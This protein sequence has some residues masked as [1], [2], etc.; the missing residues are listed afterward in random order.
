M[1][2]AVINTASEDEF[3][4]MIASL[5]SYARSVEQ[6]AFDMVDPLNEPDFDGIEGPQVG[7]A[8]YAGILRK[9]ALK[10]DAMGLTDIKFDGPNTSSVSAAVGTYIPAMLSDSVVMG[11]IDHFGLHSYSGSTG[12]ADTLIK[13]SAYPNRNFWMTEFA[14]P[15]DVMSLLS[16]NPSGLQVWEGYD[17]VYNHAILAGRG[18]TPPNDDTFA[19]ALIA[20][21]AATGIYT[22]RQMFYQFAQLARYVPAG[23]VRIGATGAPA[24]VT[25]FAFYHA[26]SGRVT[27]FGRNISASTAPMTISLSGLPS[28]TVMQ[29]YETTMTTNFVRGRDAIVS[30]GS[31]FYSA[32]V[33]SFFTITAAGA[34]DTTPPAVSVTS[35]SAGATVGGTITVAAT[36]SDAAGVAGVQ[37]RLDGVNLGAEV[38]AAPFS[39]TWNTTTAQNGTH[40]LTAVARDTAG[41]TTTSSPV[42]VS[43]S[44]GAAVPLAIDVTAF[45][46][47]SSIATTIATST[48]STTA[49]SELL[50]ALVSAADS[51]AGGQRVNSVTGAGLTWQ[52]VVRTGAQRGVAEIWRAFAPAVVT[53]VS[54][55]ATLAQSASASITVISFRGADP[56][57][58]NG[59]GAIGATGTGNAA[60]GAPSASLVTTRNS[61]W[62][63]GVGND[64][65]SGTARTLGSSQTMVHQYLGSFGDTFWVQRRTTTTPLAGSVVTINDTAPTGDRFNFSLCEILPK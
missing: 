44:N 18:S 21:N 54:V 38:T 26:A 64:W 23:S 15:S 42:I 22:P 45:G 28:L 12:G 1:G 11:R 19:P 31:L 17:S 63:I 60:S 27:V 43:V 25:L 40:T 47:R 51:T 10:L 24:G 37:F 32:P 55:T 13:N 4:E 35:P 6:L 39:T 58:T 5:V 33:N 34:P 14:V 2:G 9:L 8:Q 56:S 57:G 59:S 65:D 53:N 50:L 46:D 30:N 49:G 20:Y 52:L 16:Q 3:V 29:S 61:S 62:V 41:N 36:A 7:A 48:F